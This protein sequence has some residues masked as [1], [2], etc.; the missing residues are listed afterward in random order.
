MIRARLWSSHLLLA[1][2]LVSSTSNGAP[3]ERREWKPRADASYYQGT[4]TTPHGT[5]NFRTTEHWVLIQEDATVTIA[6]FDAAGNEMGKIDV[7][8][9]VKS[10][11]VASVKDVT[12]PSPKTESGSADFDFDESAYGDEESGT[13]RIG[14]DETA[15]SDAASDVDAASEDEAST[16]TEPN[17]ERRPSVSAARLSLSLGIGKEK[18][19]AEG[20]VSAYQGSASIGGTSIRGEGRR[21]E[22]LGVALLSAHN[23]STTVTRLDEATGTESEGESKFLRLAA[24]AVVFYDFFAP[25]GDAEPAT[26]LGLGLGLGGYRMPLLAVGDDPTA[27]AELELRS[28][29]GP[30]IGLVYARQLAARHSLGLEAYVQ[31]LT[32]VGDGKAMSTNVYVFWRHAFVTRLYTE[33]GLLSGRDQVSEPV[34]CGSASKCSETSSATSTIMQA[35]VGLGLAL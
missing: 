32:L 16:A 27:A 12:E 26:T 14:G 10:A 28:A 5:T 21:G 1:L 25:A 4:I 35:R 30:V 19:S 34:D 9:A 29:I 13:A 33:V 15:T 31:P 6:A 18:L 24:R 20:G 17:A 22:W 7:P 3:V 23:F 8:P 11:P 2:Q